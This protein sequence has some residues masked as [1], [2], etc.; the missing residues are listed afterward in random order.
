MFYVASALLLGKG[1]SFSK[2]GSLL[3]AFGRHLVITGDV[4]ARFH[5]YL[6]DAE[7]DRI[8]GDYS[9]NQVSPRLRSDQCLRRRKN[10]SL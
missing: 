1:L 6:I 8:K 9:A 10:F 4:E 2:H 5:R 3:A 7:D